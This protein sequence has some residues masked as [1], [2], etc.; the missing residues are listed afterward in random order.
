MMD[1]AKP[2]LEYGYE[3]FEPRNVD[4]LAPGMR[5]HTVDGWQ[6]VEGFGHIYC[7]CAMRVGA[8][9]SRLRV[10]PGFELVTDMEAKAL[11]GWKSDFPEYG[12]QG[13][14]YDGVYTI[15]EWY[16]VGGTF[17]VYRPIQAEPQEVE[18]VAPVKVDFWTPPVFDGYQLACDSHHAVAEDG[19]YA[20]EHDNL[21]PVAD[22]KPNIWLGYR[23]AHGPLY[24]K[25]QPTCPTCWAVI[26]GECGE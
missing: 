4:D 20:L 25:V 7:V 12:L 21:I 19:L 9:F 3:F 10:V 2:K 14:E 17:G 24:R 8:Y 13:L 18:I 23:M 26:D 6:C 22:W 5:V 16:E 15:K 1:R 11:K